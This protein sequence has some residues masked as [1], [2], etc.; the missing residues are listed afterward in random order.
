[1]VE[2]FFINK[3]N[4]GRAIQYFIL[5]DNVK[6]LVLVDIFSKDGFYDFDLTS[7]YI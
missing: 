7:H 5:F 4:T 2:E 3:S 6:F 1:M